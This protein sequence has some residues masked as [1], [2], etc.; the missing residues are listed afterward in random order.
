MLFQ[1]FVADL[2]WLS[3]RWALVLRWKGWK[4][5]RIHDSNFEVSKLQMFRG[6][7][8]TGILPALVFEACILKY[9]EI[10]VH[11][12]KWQ[13]KVLTLILGKSRWTF[14]LNCSLDTISMMFFRI[15]YGLKC[16]YPSTLANSLWQK[17]VLYSY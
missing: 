11:G 2:I 6:N 4:Y 9:C 14:P 15:K 7:L 8:Y 3:H 12:G 17:T 5:W 16:A 10:R 1:P 13:P